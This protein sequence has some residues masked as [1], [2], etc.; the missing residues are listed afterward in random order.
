MCL[1]GLA[2][3]SRRDIQIAHDLADFGTIED[4]GLRP[5]TETGLP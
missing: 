3:A 1:L 2:A 5:E 4:A